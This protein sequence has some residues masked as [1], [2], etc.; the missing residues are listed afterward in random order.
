QKVVF[1][2]INATGI[3]ELRFDEFITLTD[4]LQFSIDGTPLQ[5]K[6]FSA[7]NGNHITLEK[8]DA[9]FQPVDRS[10]SVTNLADLRGNT[11]TTSSVPIAYSPQKGDLV[12]NEI[13]FNP[14]NESDDNKPNQSEYIE[15]YNIRDYALSLE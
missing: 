10:L 5:I 12:I 6:S 13:M 2:K 15:L 11:T 8:V 3:I 4:E 7:A 14:L 9:S 1:A